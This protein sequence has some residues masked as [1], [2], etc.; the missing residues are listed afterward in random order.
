MCS[1]V[2]LDYT[3]R[4][5]TWPVKLLEVSVAVQTYKPTA[6]LEP[7]FQQELEATD[8]YS[9]VNYSNP[10]RPVQR[11]FQGMRN[12]RN[13]WATPHF[14]LILQYEEKLPRYLSSTLCWI[15]HFPN[16]P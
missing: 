13:Q 5:N 15:V 1:A 2:R 7:E 16:G 11:L 14:Q 9:K 12:E 6:N 3:L 10:F 4:G 8:Q